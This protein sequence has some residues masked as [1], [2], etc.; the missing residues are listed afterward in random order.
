MLTTTLTLKR[1]PSATREACAWFLPGPGPEAWLATVASW[2]VSIE[3]A[4][5]YA[6]P[7]AVGS[8]PLGALVV[9]K[10]AAGAS[11]GVGCGRAL[12]YGFVAEGLYAPTDATPWPP[13]NEAEWRGLSRHAVQV[14]HPVAGLCGFDA[15]D[16]LRA[17]ELVAA[18]EI[19]EE[20][21][22]LARA[23]EP[24]NTRLRNVRMAMPISLEDLFGEASKDIGGE[25]LTE[26]PPAKD[27]PRPGLPAK[28]AQGAM[29]TGALGARGLMALLGLV[30]RG[31][32]PAT[33][34]NHLENWARQKFEGVSAELEKARHRELH[35]LLEMLERDPT[36]GLRHAISLADLA[37]RGRA[38]AS[39]RLASRSLDFNLRRIGGGGAADGWSVPEN[40][41]SSLATR[42]RAAAQRETALGNHRR[43]ACIFAELLGDFSAAAEMLKRGRF[44]AEAAVLYRERLR[45]ELAEAECLAEGGFYDEAIA[46]H[47]R[48]E[49]W[50]EVAA[51]QEKAGRPEAARAAWR[52]A[53]EK[54]LAGGD[55]L[56]A[57]RLLEARLDAP[58][59]ALAQLAEAWPHGGQALQCLMERFALHGRRHDHA[60]ITEL[61]G[62]LAGKE[63][64]AGL[65]APLIG[66]LAGLAETLVHEPNRMAAAEVVRVRVAGALAARRL[67]GAD[68]VAVLRALTRIEPQDRVLKR[69]VLRFRETRKASPAP[70]LPAVASTAVVM[71]IVP[72]KKAPISL[73]KVGVWLVIQADEN[74]IRAVA[75]TAAGKLFFTRGTWS[76]AMQS[77][78]WDDPQPE[79]KEAPLLAVIENGARVMLARPFAPALSPR[80]FP[81]SDVFSAVSM[82]VVTPPWWTEDVVQA[83][84]N[85]RGIWV[86][87]GVQS[88]VVLAS[89]VFDELAHSR[90]ITDALAA[91]HVEA[92]ARVS[93]QA[94]GGDGRIALGWGRHLL[95]FDGDREAEHHDLGGEI[96]EILL[97]SPS[98]PG[99]V[100]L[101]ERGV[102]FVDARSGRVVEIDGR[103]ERPRGAWLGDGRLLLIGLGEGRLMD[104]REDALVS[105]GWFEF[106]GED[107][108]A[109][110]CAGHPREFTTFDSKGAGQRWQLVA[111]LSGARG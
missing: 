6:V 45:N 32:G 41:R 101:L 73:P 91:V 13:I 51:L 1:T 111:P 92:G 93:L 12:P 98:R 68:E 2:P 46:I 63:P 40:I 83:S 90:D 108:L 100:V 29:M 76:G 110:T 15:G 50:A 65:A 82:R 66:H 47:E 37:N 109:V 42:Y 8:R 28:L 44:F 7:D 17:W 77:L 102:V 3:D 10:V 58:E 21:W 11:A 24:T 34:V 43:A 64:P 86:L 67:D 106:K 36:Q 56:G 87:R 38:E 79:S 55:R 95:I 99:W 81:L 26:L 75:R 22:N 39:A 61:L 105:V 52:R 31:E 14:W 49:R 20:R 71:K 70:S 104:W 78:D 30:P 25:P 19:R 4:L 48:G 62:E 33:W 57:A 85:G 97:A 23:V 89:Y 80:M 27:E 88:R 5:F 69:D 60:A 74:G 16:A 84:P 9:V 107:L 72:E 94:A 53:V 35:R 18:P 59:E 54:L 103:M 96:R